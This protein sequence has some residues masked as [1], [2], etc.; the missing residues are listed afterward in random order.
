MKNKN[1]Y[2]S[3]ILA[4]IHETAYDLYSADLL[5]ESKMKEF[6]EICLSPIQSFKPE[7][8]KAIRQ[9]QNVSQEVFAKYL[10]VSSRLILQWENG[11]KKPKGSSLKL[12]N[13][14]KNKGISILI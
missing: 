12:L 2:Q 13:L 5:S 11:E 9:E 1:V 8:I 4:S 7:E 14:V 6:D 10:N 3:D